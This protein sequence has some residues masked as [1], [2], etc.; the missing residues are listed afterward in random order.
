LT[1][2]A[3][4]G[5]RPELLKAVAEQGYE[6][7]TP[8][9]VQAI[10]LVLAGR[11]VMGGAQTGTG[12][13]AGFT[14]PLLQRLAHHANTSVSPARHPVRA[15]ILAPTRELA[16]Q[17]EESVRVYGKYI[18]LRSVQIF[19]GVPMD[20][21]TEALRRGVEILVATPGRLL[22][23]VQQRTL[24]L[25]QVE[26]FVL[27]EADRML[28]MGFI[29]D[30]KR[31]VALLTARKQNLLFSATLSEEIRT[32]AKSF[33]RDPVAVQVAPKHATAELVAH[34]VHPVTRE[35]KREL[36]VHLVK[37]RGM[38]QVLVFVATRI[39]ANR[40]A[41]Q[42]NREGV[43]A[44]AI[45]G[46]RSQAER[47]Q[48][49]EDFKAGK[50]GILVAT[51]VAAR[52]L[53]IEELPFVV[54]FE[55][56]NSPEDYVHRIGRTGRAGAAGT[57]I[58]LVCPEEQERLAEI[59]KTIRIRIPR[60]V[61]S[62]FGHRSEAP[63]MEPPRRERRREAERD[64]LT[65]SQPRRRERGERE[66]ASAPA[67]R[68]A[69]APAAKPARPADPIFSRPYEPGAAPPASPGS[70]SAPG[71]PAPQKRE[72]QVAALLGGFVRKPS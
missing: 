15:L 59:E 1:T 35:R 4:L 8:I 37:A 63:L 40:L 69:P 70:A 25:S 68:A 57:A 19:G 2:F 21:Q 23:H 53:D 67:P 30:V 16:A 13:T 38:K 39:G 41:Y 31:I 32:L 10:P 24:S 71:K 5:L 51:D 47:M 9:Q 43:H 27:D 46:D 58:S 17:V 3:D 42:L 48:A 49:L 54:N 6:T 52:G 50:V 65:Q 29:P 36:F 11:D 34:L 26:I 55:L 66:P 44:T 61:V 60:E 45:H 33:L 7:P 28:D 56:P 14:L 20:P 64:P 12:K 72:R 22:D 18:P 62:G